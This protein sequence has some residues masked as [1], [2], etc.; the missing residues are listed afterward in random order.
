VQ[1]N[2]RDGAVFATSTYF[3][4]KPRFLYSVRHALHPAQTINQSFLMA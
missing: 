2:R 3:I 1:T 4:N